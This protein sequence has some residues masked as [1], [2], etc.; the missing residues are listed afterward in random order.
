MWFY[1]L[2]DQCAD[3]R[4]SSF[5]MQQKCKEA[6]VTQLPRQSQRLVVDS[7]V[8]RNLEIGRDGRRYCFCLKWRE[9][10]PVADHEYV[11]GEREVMENVPVNLKKKQPIPGWK[12]CPETQEQRWKRERRVDAQSQ[13]Q[14][15]AAESDSWSTEGFTVIRRDWHQK[16][17][18][19]RQPGWG[20][21]GD[22]AG[23]VMLWGSIHLTWLQ[24]STPELML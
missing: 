20:H 17:G 16:S 1:F 18:P 21:W 12:E 22:A 15:E 24:T 9:N 7:V 14:D 6:M 3:G 23:W 19:L 5:I 11:S 2:A 10:C 13:V 4:I 8:G